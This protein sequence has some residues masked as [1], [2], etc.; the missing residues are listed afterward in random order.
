MKVKIEPTGKKKQL[1][2]LEGVLGVYGY[3][4]ESK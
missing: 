2:R 1:A 3:T 4:T